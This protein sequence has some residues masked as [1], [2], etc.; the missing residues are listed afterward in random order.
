MKA[1]FEIAK[2]LI[3]IVAQTAPNVLNHKNV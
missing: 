1:G 3:L 2:I